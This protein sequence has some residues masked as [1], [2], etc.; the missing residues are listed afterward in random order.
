MDSMTHMQHTSS[1]FLAL[2]SPGLLLILLVLIY[3]YFQLIGPLR[4]RFAGASPVSI[5]KKM[6]FL[7]AI[8]LIYAAQGSPINYYSHGFSFSVHMFQQTLVYLILPPI[9]FLSLPEWL[10]RPLLMKP[11][12]RKLVFPWTHPLIAGLLFNLIFSFYHIPEIFNYT[13]DHPIMHQ[14]YHWILAITA[15]IMWCPVFCSVPEW[16]RMNDLQQM[17]YVFFNGVLLT[18]ACALII[19]SNKELYPAYIQGAQMIHLF[20]T[21]LED[22]QLGGTLMKVIQEFVYGTVLAYV[23]FKW[24]RKEKTKEDSEVNEETAVDI[25]TLHPLSS[26]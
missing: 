15:F 23:F 3:V 11:I 8:V 22:Q 18:P 21:P 17:G 16:R 19:F 13:F 20:M 1:G 2:W 12:L 4:Q 10:I 7:L 14:T 6:M 26:H 9:L 5:G 25:Q 24:Y